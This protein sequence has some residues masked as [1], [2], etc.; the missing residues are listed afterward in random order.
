MAPAKD[1]YTLREIEGRGWLSEEIVRD[2]L[3]PPTRYIPPASGEVRQRTEM[4]DG[5]A[6]DMRAVHEAERTP[7][8]QRR[9]NDLLESA[10]TARLKQE[11]RRRAEAEAI[12]REKRDGTHLRANA[13]GNVDISDGMPAYWVH[14]T[15]ARPK[16]C[17]RLGIKAIPAVVDWE[18]CRGRNSPV[19]RGAVILKRDHQR[20]LDALTAKEQ[21]E[22]TTEVA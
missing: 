22:A 15:P 6:W 14:I 17:A 1:W 12:E 7:E 19:V 5:Q 3:G 20:Y 11:S 9:V 13:Y 16:L 4:Q 18:T 2:L 10:R 21:G 8:W